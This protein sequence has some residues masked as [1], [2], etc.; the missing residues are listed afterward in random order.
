MSIAQFIASI[1]YMASY[2]TPDLWRHG[3][4]RKQLMKALR[5]VG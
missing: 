4:A 2:E 1:L 5:G 3:L